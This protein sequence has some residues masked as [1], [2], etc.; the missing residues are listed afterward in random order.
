MTRTILLSLAVLAA[1]GC[2][3]VN[4]V[5]LPA[6]PGGSDFFV[7]AGD[8][9]EPHDVLGAIQVT[10]SGVLLLGNFDVVGTD[11]E[12][13]FKDVLIPEAKAM[14]GNGVVRVR[15]HMTQYT[16]WARA[17]GVLFFFAPLPSSVTITGQVVKLKAGASAPA[18]IEPVASV[19]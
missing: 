1:S 3:V 9:K 15:Y 11:L 4:T 18:V 8:I 6:V 5:T 16:P 17:L 19:R 14:G 12:T 2:T 7:T 13:G 10:R